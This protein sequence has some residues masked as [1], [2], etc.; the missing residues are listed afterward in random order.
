MTIETLLLQALAGF[1]VTVGF[2]VLFHVPRDLLV[3]AGIVGM[4]GHLLRFSLRSLGLSNE[5]ATFLG[6]LVVGLF[7]YWMAKQIHSPRLVFT[8]TGIISMVPGTAA[9]ETIMY[10]STNKLLEGVQSGVRASLLTGAIGMGLGIARI[11][12]ELG[13]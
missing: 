10:L 12:V 5:I 3:R 6:S 11:V 13:E 7:G 9:Y 4:V 8:L 1:I 2:G